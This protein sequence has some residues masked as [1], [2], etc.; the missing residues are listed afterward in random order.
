[1][2]LNDTLRTHATSKYRVITLVH[3]HACA[4]CLKKKKFQRVCRKISIYRWK[5][6]FSVYGA[7]IGDKIHR[8]SSIVWYH[9]FC[10]L[11]TY[12]IENIVRV[13][14]HHSIMSVCME[15]CVLKKKYQGLYM[16]DKCW[17]ASF[18]VVMIDAIW[19]EKL[20]KRSIIIPW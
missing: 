11:G 19:Y 14:H 13:V 17:K 15:K 18:C 8:F 1:M 4:S 3:I 12:I 16:H 7:V 10:W 5:I 2:F 9:E 20:K 6:I